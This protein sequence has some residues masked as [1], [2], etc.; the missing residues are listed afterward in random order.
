MKENPPTSDATGEPKPPPDPPSLL[1][2]LLLSLVSLAVGAAIWLPTVHLFFRS[3]APA[4]DGLPS[5]TRALAER[6][7]RLWTDPAL[8]ERE[9]GRMRGSNAEW[10][11]MGRS[12]LVWAVANMALRD[13]A[14]KTRY[15]EVMDRIIDETLR[16]E[17]DRGM[18]FFLMDYA[19]SSPYIEQPAA[20]MFID[21]EIALMLAH[22]RVVE[23]KEEY[24]AELRKRVDRM[25]ERMGKS[26]SCSMESYPDECWTFCNSVGLA[27]IRMADWLDGTDHTALLRRWI[28]SAKANLVHAK[29]GLLVSSFR[30]KGFPM[31]GPEGS[32]IWAVAHFL[33]IVDPEFAADQYRRARRELGATAL[34]FSWGKEWPASWE[35]PQDIDSGPIIPVV[36]VSA[37][38]SGL[39]FVGAAAFHDT[40][41]FSSL[42]TTLD[43]AGFPEERD[44]MLRYCASNQVGDAV[45]LYSMVLG[46]VWERV[47][48]GRPR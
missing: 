9:V 22:R 18:T 37:A 20:S 5:Q 12:F 39:A 48:K 7:L 17:R 33:Q 29:T 44:G 10:D 40:D 38:S 30:Y 47:L 21:G 19:R 35:G 2:R 6:H 13:P 1:R 15:L 14:S 27:A 45:L 41:Y 32:T 25:A 11:F 24:R 8:R 42:L 26:P 23:E 28:E 31:D 46:P 16:I 3:P 36:E 4:A 43:F 34:G